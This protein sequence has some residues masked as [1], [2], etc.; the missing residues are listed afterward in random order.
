MLTA[1]DF[2]NLTEKYPDASILMRVWNPEKDKFETKECGL[3]AYTEDNQFICL[4]GE[5]V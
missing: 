3:I 5:D 2:H 1:R 4:A